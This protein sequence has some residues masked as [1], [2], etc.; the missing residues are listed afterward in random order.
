MHSLPIARQKDVCMYARSGDERWQYEKMSA[1]EGTNSMDII[2][3]C[4]GRI[5]ESCNFDWT[6]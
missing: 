6:K 3:Q 2:F 5:C 1:A 4:S